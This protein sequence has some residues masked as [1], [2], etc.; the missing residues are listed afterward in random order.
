MFPKVVEDGISNHELT[1]YTLHIP[2]Y[3]SMCIFGCL[4]SKVSLHYDDDDEETDPVGDVVSESSAPIK[5]K[6]K[7][8]RS[9][10]TAIHA[11]LLDETRAKKMRSSSIMGILIPFE[12]VAERKRSKK[13]ENDKKLWDEFIKEDEEA[14][15]VEETFSKN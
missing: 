7:N 1:I 4:C 9:S 12:T 15:K 14:E 2:T 3:S 6:P 11:A 10:L 5:G 13:L 8:R